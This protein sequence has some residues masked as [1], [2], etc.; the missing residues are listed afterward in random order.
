M[1]RSASQALQHKLASVPTFKRTESATPLAFLLANRLLAQGARLF[2]FFSVMMR[3]QASDATSDS[4]STLAR[5]RDAR[6]SVRLAL[7]QC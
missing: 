6:V 5:A 3:K 1:C 4:T 7:T 2:R